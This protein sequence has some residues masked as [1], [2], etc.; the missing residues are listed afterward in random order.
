MRILPLVMAMA[1]AL[2]TVA[3]GAVLVTFTEPE[4]YVDSGRFSGDAPR[5]LRELEQHFQYLGSRYLRPDQTLRIEILDIDLAGEERFRR[6][7]NQDVRVLRGG[8]D[9][10]RMHLRYALEGSDK[11][12][13]TGEEHLSDMNYLHR[14]ATVRSNESLAYEK[15]MLEEWFRAKFGPS[16]AAAAR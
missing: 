12:A 3:Q 4:K 9:W 2:A 15:R 11:P 7:A 13:L 1:A 14:P 16:A 6:H 5:M 8:A 10:P